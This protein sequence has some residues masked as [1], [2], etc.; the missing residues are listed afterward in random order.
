MAAPGSLSMWLHCLAFT[1][2]QHH[3]RLRVTFLLLVPL[4][5][6]FLTEHRHTLISTFLTHLTSLWANVEHAV[7][8]DFVS[9]THLPEHPPFQNEKAAARGAPP[10]R[11]HGQEKPVFLPHHASSH[12]VISATHINHRFQFF[13]YVYFRIIPFFP[14]FLLVTDFP[15]ESGH[16][17]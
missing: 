12:G 2:Y 8:T 14:L 10:T 7:R 4:C 5:S 16:S 15:T 9:I 11:D 3:G 1:V 17:L 6:G 13:T